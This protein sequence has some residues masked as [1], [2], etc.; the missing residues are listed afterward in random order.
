MCIRV[1][2]L[3]TKYLS[4]SEVLK[5]RDN[6]FNTYFTGQKYQDMISTKFGSDKVA[7]IND[8]LAVGLERRLAY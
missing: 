5:F 6:A 4:S 7:Y 8:M 2:P 3:P 1:S